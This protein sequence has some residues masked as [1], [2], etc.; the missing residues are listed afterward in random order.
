MRFVCLFALALGC[1]PGGSS[2]L[3]AGGVEASPVVVCGSPGSA[4]V[5]T[6]DGCSSVVCSTLGHV[7]WP[8]ERCTR[9]RCTPGNVYAVEGRGPALPTTGLTH[10]CVQT[11][12]P[13][14]ALGPARLVADDGRTDRG[15]CP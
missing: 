7:L 13:D 10:Y 4:G 3:D 14:G 12:G 2:M 11:C 8:E 15:P 9:S 1:G 6:I 5:R